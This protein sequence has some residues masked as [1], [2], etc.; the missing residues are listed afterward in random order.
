M[1]SEMPCSISALLQRHSLSSSYG[2]SGGI[3]MAQRQAHSPSRLNQVG[4]ES[5]ESQQRR[6]DTFG[7]LTRPT[8]LSWKTWR[9]H[10]SYLMQA[11]NYTVKN[12]SLL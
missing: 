7:T 12:G 1:A 9:Q 11:Q 10:N 4:F 5:L 3:Q 2:T 6:F 8:E